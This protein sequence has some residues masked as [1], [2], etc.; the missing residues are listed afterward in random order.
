MAEVLSCVLVKGGE[1]RVPLLDDVTV[2]DEPLV[3]SDEAL[4]DVTPV[5]D[6]D[7]TGADALFFGAGG[8]VNP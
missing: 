1:G 5:M 6:D 2:D 7:E 3:A 4:V 8:G